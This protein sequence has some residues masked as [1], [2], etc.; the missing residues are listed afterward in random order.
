[1]N[2]GSISEQTN[3]SQIHIE[4]GESLLRIYVPSDE[5]LRD[6]CYLSALP[7]RLIEWMITDPETRIQY[8]IR[9]NMVVV[10][11]AILNARS[12]V[13]GHLL[14][15]HGIIE[16]ENVNVDPKRR[17]TARLCLQIQTHQ[18]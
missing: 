4:D 17:L 10:A 1:M 3:S 9:P 13:A 15:E 14:E 8:D 2:G 5:S 16:V 18:D 11:Q 7:R 6:T 12:R